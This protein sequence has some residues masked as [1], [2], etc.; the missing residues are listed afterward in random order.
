VSNTHFA[1]STAAFYDLPLA[2]LQPF[3]GKHKCGNGKLLDEFG[4]NLVLSTMAGDG[5]RRRHDVFKWGLSRWMSWAK[6]EYTCE[7]YGLFAAYINHGADTGMSARKR[8]SI[9]PDFAISST[10]GR[11]RLL[12][13]L[14]CIGHSKTFFPSDKKESDRNGAIGTPVAVHRRR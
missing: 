14:K 3:V 9:I 8:Q 6:M 4:D 1:L 7:V 12:G 10:A 13:E 2:L 5:W 11:P